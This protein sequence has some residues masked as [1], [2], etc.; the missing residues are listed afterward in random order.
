ML[1]FHINTEMKQIVDGY[2]DEL[3]QFRPAGYP[4]V[5][6]SSSE[7][8]H[9]MLGELH[10]QDL[11]K[12]STLIVTTSA[13]TITVA[14]EFLNQLHLPD[15][16]L[17]EIGNISSEAIYIGNNALN[18]LNNSNVLQVYSEA[19]DSLIRAKTIEQEAKTQL[20]ASATA[21]EEASYQLN[22]SVYLRS[23]VNS[24]SSTFREVQ[25]NITSL[26]ALPNYTQEAMQLSTQA[27]TVISD[28]QDI[29]ARLV[30]IESRI[31]GV[32]DKVV[33]ISGVINKTSALLEDT[34]ALGE[35]IYALSN[36]L[37]SL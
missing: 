15:T 4:G 36:P 13:T 16:D 24:V 35:C 37:F 17:D 25:G 22:R 10:A 1:Q 30:E 14:E 32:Q 34:N 21:L 11:T 12:N 19:N 31:P 29:E 7:S 6:S 2:S 23:K 26:L 9:C 20:S 5:C 27:S 3:D 8:S 28:L 18:I 33:N